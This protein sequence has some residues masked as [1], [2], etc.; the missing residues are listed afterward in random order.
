MKKPAS[1]KAK[2]QATSKLLKRPAAALGKKKAAA[3]TDGENQ[4][5]E[6]VDTE[7]TAKKQKNKEK[8]GKS[9]NLKEDQKPGKKDKWAEKAKSIQ[10]SQ[11]KQPDENQTELRD[12]KKAYFFRKQMGKLPAD[13]KALFDSNTVTRADKTALVNGLVVRDSGGKLS[14]NLEGPVVSL[15]QSHYTD[16]SGS[17]KAKGYPRSLMVAKLGGDL[18]FAQALEKGEIRETEQD[19]STFYFFNTITIEKKVGAKAMTTGQVVKAADD[20]QIGAL[21]AFVESFQPTFRTSKIFLHFSHFWHVKIHFGFPF[22]SDQDASSNSIYKSISCNI[23]F[24][25][26][27]L[28]VRFLVWLLPRMQQILPL[29]PV[30][31]LL[32]SHLRRC[33]LLSQ[34]NLPLRSSWSS[35]VLRAW[36]VLWWQ[37]LTKAWDGGRACVNKLER[38]WKSLRSRLKRL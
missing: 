1:K 28:Q 6:Q 16:V 33:N 21:S 23:F 25:L 24:H 7:P 11:D 32:R 2:S 3:P 38:F 20:Q 5:E 9:K 34:T 35:Q 8:S 15:L 30:D 27:L 31:T 10:I 26:S 19:G 37:R 18:A 17:H 14:L 12:E 4:T 29:A 13:V 22:S 36:M